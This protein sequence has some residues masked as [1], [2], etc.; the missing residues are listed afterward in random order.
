MADRIQS[1]ARV[2]GNPDWMLKPVFFS[3]ESVVD[4]MHFFSGPRAFTDGWCS[5]EPMLFPDVWFFPREQPEIP[6]GGYPFVDCLGC[7][8]FAVLNG[9]QEGACPVPGDFLGGD[10]GLSEEFEAASVVASGLPVFKSFEPGGHEFKEG[11]EAAGSDFP[12]PTNVLGVK[13]AGE[14]G[15]RP[16][17]RRR[18]SV[19]DALAC[20]G[21]QDISLPAT[22]E[23][24]WA[25]L[26]NP[27]R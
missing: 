7:N 14:G 4:E 27:A 26:K 2:S 12:S 5:G 16:G 21:V 19:L 8:L 20:R 11:A 9:F 25:A 13:G 22:S 1:G 18:S 10:K 24:V 23:T 15:G 17:H 3:P 6:V